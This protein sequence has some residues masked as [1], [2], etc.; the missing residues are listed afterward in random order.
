MQKFFRVTIKILIF[1]FVF[2]VFCFGLSYRFEEERK[3]KKYN[4]YIVKYSGEYGVEERLV[5]AVIKTESGFD[6]KAISQ[7][8]ACGLMQLMPSTFR[9]ASCLFEKENY[10]TND[11]DIF[12]PEKNIKCGCKYLKYLK[13]IFVTDVEVLCAY[14]AG[15][16]RVKEWLGN[17]NYSDDGKTLK[18]IPYNETYDFV[19]KVTFY[20]KIY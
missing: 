15:E 19:K 20:T 7:K 9:Y 11:D 18:K 14:N 13:D 2:V 17:K 8:G 12:I 1:I 16:G 3:I 10:N 6:E 5:K 4:D